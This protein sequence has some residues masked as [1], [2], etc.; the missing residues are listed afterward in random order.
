MKRIIPQLPKGFVSIEY[1]PTKGRNKGQIY[2][3]YFIDQ[4][5]VV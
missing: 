5:L 3:A 2:R 1:T 4:S